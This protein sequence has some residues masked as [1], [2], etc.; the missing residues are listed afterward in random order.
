VNYLGKPILGN[1]KPPK[2]PNKTRDKTAREKREGMSD[3]H[4]RNVA[5][6]PSC[7]SG[8]R[9]CDPHH[10]RIKAERGVGMK[11]TDKWCVPLTRDEHDEVHKVGSRKEASW[12]KTRGIDCYVLANALWFNRGDICA[13]RK[14]IEA[15]MTVARTPD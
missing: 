11:A 6:L 13:M 12:F 4:R 2:N 9:P 15:N 5:K 10:L 14:V 3:E 8:K 7:I 1:F